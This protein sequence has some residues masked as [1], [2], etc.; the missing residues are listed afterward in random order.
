MSTGELYK[1][2]HE[3]HVRQSARRAHSA[4]KIFTLCDRFLDAVSVIDI[5]CGVG[6]LLSEFQK[7][8]FEVCGVEG[9]WLES[10]SLRFS[11]EALIRADLEQSFNLDR[12]F[13]L[14]ISTEVA[15]HL[16]PDRAIGFVEDLTNLSDVVLFSAA[17]RG[18]GGTGHK[19]EQ[20]QDYWVG[21]F[22]AQDYCFYDAFRPNLWTDPEVY[23]WFKQ[24]LML[25]VKNGVP[26]KLELSDYVS[27]AKGA[28]MIVPKYHDKIVRRKVK[29]LQR[30][31]KQV[32]E[33]ATN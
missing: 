12:K 8:G 24:N 7:H 4:M 25:F 23:D 29:Q 5:G 18:Q 3:G 1:N 15:E 20:W 14:C 33:V 9:D 27:S 19:N 16:E 26:V 28:R 6:H 13:D 30:L 21:L 22:A 10:S 11:E 17:I 32:N 31:R 2:L